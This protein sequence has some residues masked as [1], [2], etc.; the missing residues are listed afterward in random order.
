[1]GDF[2]D[3]YLG[4]AKAPVLTIFIGGNH[5]ASNYLFDLYHGGWVCPNIYFMG[6]SGVVH[7]GGLRIGGL[8][9]IFNDRHYDLGY[10][11]RPP[12]D[13]S[14]IRSI[15]HFRRLET[16]KLAQLKPGSLDIFMSH[17]WPTGIYNHGN[18]SELLKW[19][20][21]FKAEME[22]NELGAKPLEELLVKI[23]PKNWFSAHLHSFF[24]ASYP[25][26]DGSK[27]EFMALDKCLPNR[28]FLEIVEI[29]DDG[30]RKLSYDP[31]WLEIVRASDSLMNTRRSNTKLP[32]SFEIAH[33]QQLSKGYEIPKN[34]APVSV[35]ANS[36]PQ[37]DTFCEALGIP[38]RVS[39]A[40][41]S[42]K[43]AEASNPDEISLDLGEARTEEEKNPD[44]ITLDL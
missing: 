22:R 42:N 39:K 8:S 4:K 19:K 1:M 14:A 3:Y 25:H 24:K 7:Y 41:L 12:Y 23:R 31:E 6:Y 15:Y 28:K 38:N 10:Y 40:M 26:A 33:P 43:L 35:G 27:T 34:F 44:E 21:F 32:G 9:G 36:N 5:E 18:T 29:P 20:P 37:T 17:E 2:R 11:E 30:T 13:H 16:F